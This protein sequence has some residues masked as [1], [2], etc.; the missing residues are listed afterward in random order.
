MGSNLARKKP[1]DR[2][3]EEGETGRMGEGETLLAAD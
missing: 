1:L 3:N 2:R